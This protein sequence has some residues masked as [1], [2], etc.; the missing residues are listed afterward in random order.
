[1]VTV[2]ERTEGRYEVQDVEFG[3]VYRWCPECVIVECDCGERLTLTSSIVTCRCGADHTAL[4][5]EEL[6]AI[7]VLGDEALHPWRSLHYFADTGL[8]Y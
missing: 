5:R 2:I 4:V 3:S 6:M 1:M 8:P 7:G